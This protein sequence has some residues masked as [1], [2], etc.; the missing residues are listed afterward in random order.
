V[1][2]DIVETFVFDGMDR[3]E[4]KR[5]FEE[6]VNRRETDRLQQ[7]ADEL[8]ARLAENRRS[9]AEWN[10]KELVVVKASAAVLFVSLLCGPII[11]EVAVPA[12]LVSGLVFL[13][14]SCTYAGI[15]F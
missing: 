8:S 4:F 12:I 3:E 2:L 11:P 9:S 13:C 15:E 6:E 5:L 10:R 1:N 14:A 7:E